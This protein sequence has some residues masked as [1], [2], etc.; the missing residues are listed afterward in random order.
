VRKLEVALFY[1]FV[2][3]FLNYCSKVM[4]LFSYSDKVVYTLLLRVMG[5]AEFSRNKM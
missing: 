2:F 1:G 3:I 4:A 5:T